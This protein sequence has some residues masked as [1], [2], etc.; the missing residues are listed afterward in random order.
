MKFLEWVESVDYLVI[1]VSVEV[2]LSVHGRAGDGFAS[3]CVPV[4]GLG[5]PA[6]WRACGA[7]LCTVR[8]CVSLERNSP[9]RLCDHE[10][11][12]L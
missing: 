2:G 10:A 12:L 9:V 1:P 6:S 4:G 11:V 7:I 5:R 8:E 3:I